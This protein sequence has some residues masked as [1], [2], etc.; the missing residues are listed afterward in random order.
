MH[1]TQLSSHTSLASPSSLASHPAFISAPHTALPHQP[2]FMP[3]TVLAPQNKAIIHSSVSMRHTPSQ[4]LQ[5]FPMM[6]ALPLHASDEASSPL[7]KGHRQ[8]L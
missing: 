4:R 7:G 3:I 1:H 6:S 5:R 2:A 8:S